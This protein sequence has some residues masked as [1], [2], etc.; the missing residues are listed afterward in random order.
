MTN[1]TFKY[2]TADL[3]YIFVRVGTKNL[4]LNDMTDEQFVQW[5]E[6]KFGVQIR[7]DENALGTPWSSEQKV[8]FLNDISDKL[9]QPAVVM[10]REEAR[11]E[12]DSL[13]QN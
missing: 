8:D 2:K 5:A 4:S 3:D 12:F 10:V 1:T 13:K 7:D 9:G 11:H 6:G